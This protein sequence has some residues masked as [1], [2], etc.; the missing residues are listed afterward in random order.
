MSREPVNLDCLSIEP[1]DYRAFAADTTNDMRLRNYAE[2][3]AQA[4][5]CR[6][7]GRV[8]EAVS[9]ERNLDRFYNAL[10]TNLQW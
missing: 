3:K 2:M 4:M 7:A 9:I 6:L 10:P 1:D 8:A 5:E